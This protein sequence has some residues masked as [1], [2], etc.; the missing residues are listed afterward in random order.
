M[1]TKD[2]SEPD[3]MASIPMIYIK[4]KKPDSGVLVC[5]LSPL[6]WR[7]SQRIAGSLEGQL[8]CSTL[9]G[10]RNR[11][12]CL[13]T[14]QRAM[15][16]SGLKTIDLQSFCCYGTTVKEWWR[17]HGEQTARSLV[18]SRKS[19]WPSFIHNFLWGIF[20]V[21]IQSKGFVSPWTNQGLCGRS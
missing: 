4:K 14:R 1:D 7:Q 10:K 13:A 20:K 18:N 6:I 3:E 15:V 19:A 12:Q 9:Q 16:M 11:R 5:N 2:S 8:E 17:Y 21:L